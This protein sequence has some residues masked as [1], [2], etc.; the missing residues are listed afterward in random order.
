MDNRRAILFTHFG[1]NWVR[2]SERVLLDL[3]GGLDQRRFRPLLWCNA[4]AMAEQARLIGV[5]TFTSPMSYYLDYSSPRPNPLA[6]LRLMRQGARLIRRER[7]GMV[8]AN[9]AAPCQWMAPAARVAGV[10]LLVHLHTPYH[11][12]SRYVTLLH[13]ASRIVGASRHVLHGLREDGLGGERL[14]V[15][16]N[17]IDEARLSG[18]D[19]GFRRQLGI[20]PE[21]FVILSV[22]SLI[23]RKGH[24]RLIAALARMRGDRRA[25]LVVVGEGEERGALEQAVAGLGLE[26]RVHLLGGRPALATTYGEAD[27]FAL[28]SRVEAFG[29][30]LAEAAACGLPCLA[31]A[32]GGIPEV[33][34]DG[35]T[36]LLVHETGEEDILASLARNLDYLVADAAMRVAMGSAG[37]RLVSRD[38]TTQRMVGEF[39]TLYDEAIMAPAGHGWRG[40][41]LAPYLQATTGRLRRRLGA[42]A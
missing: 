32:T 29:L 3:M 22:G 23:H 25:H 36:G 33:V 28:A 16:M 30:V 19:Q 20:P 31:V 8:H 9:G 4:E 34:R 41:T 18:P 39:E 6:F 21:D 14:R 27:C 11:A 2:G 24:D 17:G 26:G 35:E 10:P 42:P 13:M 40:V 15:V 38:F 1:E 5:R 37:Q 12:R 7:V